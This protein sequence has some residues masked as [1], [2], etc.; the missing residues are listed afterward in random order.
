MHRRQYTS[1]DKWI[2]VY[3]W[4][5][6]WTSFS[7][8][9]N[10]FICYQNCVTVVTDKLS[11]W[12]KLITL[13][14]RMFMKSGLWS[15]GPRVK[16]SLFWES[17]IFNLQTSIVRLGEFCHFER[18][19]VVVVRM[20]SCLSFC[21]FLFPVKTVYLFFYVYGNSLE[22]PDNYEKDEK[23]VEDVKISP[24]PQKREYISRIWITLFS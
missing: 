12:L 8:S 19:G 3:I 22:S 24:L 4:S 16:D 15:C 7:C 5:L 20:G 21:S 11:F 17:S 14:A 2:F 13:E 23:L 10:N 1:G 9:N 18:F 6:P